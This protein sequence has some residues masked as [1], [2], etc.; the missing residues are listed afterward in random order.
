MTRIIQ[1][2][3]L[4][5]IVVGVIGTSSIRAYGVEQEEA[6]IPPIVSW[7]TFI[8]AT[9]D[10]K[11]VSVLD[12]TADSAG[13]TYVT[14]TAEASWGSPVDAY[15]AGFEG[16]AAKFNPS[17]TLLWH[18]FFG[19]SEGDGGQGIAID[20]SGNSYIIGTAR[21]SWAS[22]VQNHLGF[23]DAFVQALDSNG[24]RLWNTFIGT[25]NSDLGGRDIAV[26][27]AGSIYVVGG[28][29]TIGSRIFI[30]RLSAANGSRSW[31]K[32]LGAGYAD[33]AAVAADSAGNSYVAGTVYESFGV[34]IDDYDDNGPSEQTVVA[35]LNTSGTLLWNTF[36]PASSPRVVSIDGA[37][38]IYVGG[39]SKL[40]WGM[41]VTA[42]SGDY[43][44]FVQKL[45]ASGQRIW[46]TFVGGLLEGGDDDDSISSIVFDS[47]GSI[48]AGG[49]AGQSFG[50]PQNSFNGVGDFFVAKLL[51]SGALQ[52][53]AFFGSTSYDEGY[54]LAIDGADNLFLA[55][56]SSSTWGASPLVA[57]IGPTDG[58][59]VKFTLECPQS[60]IFWIIPT[61]GNKAVIFD[62]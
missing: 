49:H 62:L 54:A 7:N 38:S 33:G 52:C 32:L 41:P 47:K 13:N 35:K 39:G 29:Q 26:D 34:P 4:G 1:T 30:A 57:F 37:G 16:F 9:D 2:V 3:V 40:S 60:S 31:L 12:V 44:G 25:R 11:K 24:N 20:N 45:T 42:P 28:Y 36:I 51:S 58:A 15:V 53:N 61:G 48:F 27:N 46:N 10:T 50:A 55:G 59:L 43:D 17:G 23:G 22:P 6:V 8:G 18:T 5:L 21:G 56:V 19:S 14:G